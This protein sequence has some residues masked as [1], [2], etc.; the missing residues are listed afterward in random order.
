[1]TNHIAEMLNYHTWAN[2]TLLGHVKALPSTVLH[3]DCT[4]SYQTIAHAFSHIYAVDK[5]WYLVLTG[6]TMQEALAATMSLNL[7]ALDTIEEYVG[8]YAE[9]ADQYKHWLNSHTDLEHTILLDNPYAGVRQ[10]RLSEI[11]LQVVTHGNYHRGNITTMLRQLG[12]ASTM[13]DYA[14]FWYQQPVVEE[15]I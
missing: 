15:A 14:L 13:T 12:L 6:T 5:M 9:L 11:M 8:K 4:N 1:M 7:N 2:Q 10:T 3:Q